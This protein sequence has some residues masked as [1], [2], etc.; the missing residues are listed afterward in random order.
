MSD[1]RLQDI[2]D[3]IQQDP[4]RRGLRADPADNLITATAGDFE[5]ACRTIAL[6]PMPRVA[7]ITGFTIPTARPP[8]GETDGPPGALY[9]ARALNS[10]GIPVA[11]ATD[12]TS[13]PALRAGV[14]A[15]HLADV[16]V[17]ELPDCPGAYGRSL[18]ENYEQD[19]SCYLNEFFTRAGPA[20]VLI[21]LERVGPNHTL[22]SLRQSGATVSTATFLKSVPAGHMGRCYSMRGRDLT[23]FTRPA[24]LLFETPRWVTTGGLATIGIGDGGNEIGMGRVP[25]ETIQKN[26]ANGGLVAC[27]VRVDALVV[28]GISN[29]GGWALAAGVHLLRG[30]QPGP[31]LFDADEEK[32][33]LEV[34]IA[35][36]PLVDGV[37]LESAATVDGLPFHDYVA[38]LKQIEAIVAPD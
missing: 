28:A 34:M 5:A 15:A 36:G 21:A 16:P 37:T 25:W 27:R 10:L 14:A 7:I 32:R 13:L 9:L 8:V 4:G 20:N 17:V 22:E 18:A 11:L 30:T 6:H 24:H 33:L 23:D 2:L 29:W 35:A 3:V 1:S 12:G 38:I 19:R 26:I 31:A